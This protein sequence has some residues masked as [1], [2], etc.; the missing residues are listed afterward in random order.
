M[1]VYEFNANKNVTITMLWVMVI[2]GVCTLTM[3]C[4]SGAVKPAPRW[5]YDMKTGEIV[6]HATYDR[7]PVTLPNGNKGF[8]AKMIGCG[9]CNGETFFGNLQRATPA[10]QE[11]S[12]D[13]P[14]Q[15][16]SQIA[17]DPKLTGGNPVWVDE[18]S[19]EG[20][21]ILKAIQSRCGLTVRTRECRP[22]K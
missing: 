3:G 15:S 17:A 22:E 20:E 9:D 6:K 7:A 16:M 18:T 21:E 1:N 2:A 4:D 12:T 19:L 13:Q 8:Q 11:G 10:M 14:G 5:Y